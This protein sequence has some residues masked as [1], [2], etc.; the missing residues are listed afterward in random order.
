[1]TAYSWR[2][3]PN[4]FI[5]KVEW[6][7]VDKNGCVFSKGRK[8]AGIDCFNFGFREFTSWFWQYHVVTWSDGA[9]SAL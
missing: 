7:G 5:K 1:M 8:F 6:G 3:I 9:A 4:Y 2:G